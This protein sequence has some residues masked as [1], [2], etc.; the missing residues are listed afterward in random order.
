ME[1][2]AILSV[3]GNAIQLVD[4]TTKIVSKARSIQTSGSI[5]EQ[6][7][8]LLVSKDLARLSNTLKTDL[9]TAT[10]A[11][12][13]NDLSISRLCQKCLEVSLEIEN[14]FAD[15]DKKGLRGKWKSFRQALKAV[16]GA[17]KLAEMQTRLTLFSQQLQQRT[18]MKTHEAVT[19][20]HVDVICALKEVTAHST[21]EH[22]ATRLA[23][24]SLQRKTED[25]VIQLREEI[26]TLK[27]DL[28]K[29]IAESVNESQRVSQTE[30]KRINE[31]TNAMFKVWAAKEAMLA[32]IMVNYALTL[33]STLLIWNAE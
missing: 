5:V 32:N 24:G 17:E 1:S 10:P 16:W 29:R 8:L 3:V 27:L 20:L 9:A 30:R 6:E 28:E 15:I 18:Q 19:D 23:I 33:L 31:Y 25:Q 21:K 14:A 26:R 2:V 4:F 22:A 12:T 7:D 11:L 13:E